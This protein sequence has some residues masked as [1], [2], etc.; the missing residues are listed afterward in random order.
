MRIRIQYETVYTYATPPRSVIQVLRMTPRNHEGQHVI[1]WRLDIDANCVLKS[2]ED[3]F[4]NLVHTFTAMGPI[5]Q[6]IVSAEGEVE[7]FDTSGFVRNAVE[8]FP[9]ELYLRQSP[10]AIAD[11]R[12]KALAAS[13]E[14]DSD[15]A[16]LHTLLD[17]LHEKL[18]FD[19]DPTHGVTTAARAYAAGAAVAAD[20]A[21]IFIACAREMNVPARFVSGHIALPEDSSV[22]HAAHAWAEAYIPDYG[23]IGF[24]PALGKCPEESHVRV[25]CALDHLGAAPVRGAQTGGDGEALD[26]RINVVDSQNQ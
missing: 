4:G 9:P 2:S 10:L 21:H 15:H 26:V 13:M 1:D 18:D 24:D 11:E 16:R 17:T 8:R 23:W 14:G 20:F 25:A 22:R 5:P 6:L 19:T 12:L 7:T 3:G